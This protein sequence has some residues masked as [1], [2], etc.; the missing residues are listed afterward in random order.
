MEIRQFGEA[1]RVRVRKEGDE[2]FIFGRKTSKD[3][4]AR[5]EYRNHIY[6]NHDGRFG[7]CFM[8]VITRMWNN[9]RRKLQ[10]AGFTVKQDGAT[11]G[12]LLFDPTNSEQTKLAIRTA[13]IRLRREPPTEE[14]RIQMANRLR[15]YGATR[16]L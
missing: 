6:D 11:E 5:L 14:Q 13:G 12:T 15:E 16:S 10:T 3:M 8:F 4:P 1:N 2:H 7:V 9:T